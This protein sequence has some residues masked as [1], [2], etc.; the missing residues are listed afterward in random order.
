ML[1]STFKDRV[2]LKVHE[3]RHSEKDDVIDEHNEVLIL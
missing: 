2:Q 1:R 3:K